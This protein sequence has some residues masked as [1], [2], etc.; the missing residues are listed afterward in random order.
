MPEKRKTPFFECVPRTINSDGAPLKG[1]N[2][3]VNDLAP[4]RM[5]SPE[6][7]FFR[8]TIRCSRLCVRE[9]EPLKARVRASGCE[10]V[11]HLA[12]EYTIGE[13]W[14]ESN[15]PPTNFSVAGVEAPLGFRTSAA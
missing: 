11:S 9:G 7:D 15:K 4:I 2:Q 12:T 10:R 14:F 1:E 13:Y 8:E 5:I 3:H 6:L